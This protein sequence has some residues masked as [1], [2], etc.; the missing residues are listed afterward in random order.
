MSYKF[1]E[2]QKDVIRKTIKGELGFINVLEGSVRSGKTFITNLAWTLFILNSPHDTFLMSGESTDSLYRNV[3][4]DVVFILGQDK[5]KYQDSAKGGAQLI[6]K[7][8]GRKKICYCRGGSKSNDEGKIRGMTV[9]GWYA[10]EITLHHK[11]FV[12]QAISRMSLEGAKAIWTT[13][14]DS[15]FHYIKTDYID[16]AN[17]KGYGHWHFNLDD[18][19]SLSEEYKENIKKAYSGLFYDRFIK[20]LW[21]L[22]DGLIY[23]M[24]NKDIHIVKT[25]DREYT[26]KYV[27]VDYGTQNPT[28]FGMFGKDK[29]G[30]WYKIKEYHH[31]GRTSL[32][33]KT[34]EEYANDL[35]EFIEDDKSIQVIVDPSASSFI[36]SLKNRGIRVKKAKNDVLEGIRNVGSALSNKEILFND[37]NIET[38]KEFETYIWDE[39]ASLKGE[40]K[41]VKE[42]DHHMDNLRY[43]VNTVL[44]KK[45]SISVF[46]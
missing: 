26:K 5:A 23:D 16:Q 43:F 37:C 1:S 32:K 6:I 9:A 29:K 36:L 24:F 11:D 14:P 19:L 31:S 10:D 15:P 45:S 25:E 39:K 28:T 12:K 2:K 30:Q 3:I 34:N 42:N 18:N 35:L 8:N 44:K 20:G 22:S 38:F 41:P 40:D 46:K 17:E 13:N 33:Q 21:V 27:A 7:H 4:D